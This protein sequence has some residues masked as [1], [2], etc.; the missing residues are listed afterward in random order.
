M[1]EL[2]PQSDKERSVPDLPTRFA[3]FRKAVPLKRGDLSTAAGK[4][5]PRT[6][7]ESAR[8]SLDNRL[9]GR[10]TT[11]LTEAQLLI[12]LQVLDPQGRL[13][14]IPIDRWFDSLDAFKSAFV[15]EGLLLPSEV[16]LRRLSDRLS[17]IECVED[18][19]VILKG[20]RG[21]F[22]NMNKIEVAIRRMGPD[23]RLRLETLL[24]ESFA[25]FCKSTPD[26]A[27]A[28]TATSILARMTTCGLTQG[29]LPDLT[30]Y[31]V[32]V[33]ADLRL[34]RVAGPLVLVQAYRGDLA[35]YEE[36]INRTIEDPAYRGEDHAFQLQ[37][38]CSYETA[39]GA[40]VRHS[41]TRPGHIAAHDV[42]RVIALFPDLLKDPNS[43]DLA[44]EMRDRMLRSIKELGV[45][46][47]L[48]DK[49]SDL[50]RLP[51][52]RR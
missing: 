40:V 52:Y 11:S 38:Y 39:T 2:Q 43:L 5:F 33:D 8:S 35:L 46:R 1:R 32:K 14:D 24:Y 6:M 51:V 15:D 49:A 36:T 25:T 47:S 41:V 10:H 31:G 21:T 34:S 50:M 30:R 37:Y 45:K 13:N 48:R 27:V 9:Y 44:E 16:Q 18:L 19:S 17:S 4:I 3:L 22:E 42:G 28:L 23:L 20:I 26:Q 29:E 12:L 7:I